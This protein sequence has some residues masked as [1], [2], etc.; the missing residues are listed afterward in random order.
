[1]KRAKGSQSLI[2]NRRVVSWV[3]SPM[4]GSDFLCFVLKLL[5]TLVTL[6]WCVW[7]PCEIKRFREGFHL[8][9]C[10]HIGSEG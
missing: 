7:L 1:M 2:A 10:M 5:C 8:G 3:E 6:H 9:L 4:L